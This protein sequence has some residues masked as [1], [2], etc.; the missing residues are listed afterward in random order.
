F[1]ALT[2]AI[3]FFRFLG[4]CYGVFHVSLHDEPPLRVAPVR[5]D[6]CRCST[7]CK[8]FLA[9]LPR[10]RAAIQAKDTPAN[11]RRETRGFLPPSGTP[12]SARPCAECPRR[13]N[14]EKLSAGS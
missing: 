12:Q 10:R 7:T 8:I 4:W 6:S 5:S 14:K 2:G 9:Y 11:P 1:D 3:V 13:N